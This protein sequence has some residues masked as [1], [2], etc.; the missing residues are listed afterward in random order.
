MKTE[1]AGSG[2]LVKKVVQ[3][4]SSMRAQVTL[5]QLLAP[6]VISCYISGQQQCLCLEKQ[7]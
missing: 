4:A 5:G 7:L 2:L 3:T 1:E 6:Q